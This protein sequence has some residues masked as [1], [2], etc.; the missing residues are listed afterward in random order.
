LNRDYIEVFYLS[1]TLKA[2]MIN[3]KIVILI[4]IKR[5]KRLDD[6]DMEKISNLGKSI[7]ITGF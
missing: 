3:L 1:S 5:N 7:I 2:K 6:G 4:S